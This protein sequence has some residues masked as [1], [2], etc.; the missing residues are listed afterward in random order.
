MGEFVF[1]KLEVYKRSLKLSIEVTKVASNF[2]YKY[3]RIR[4]QLIGAIISI[5][6]NIAEANGR[7]SSKD[8]INFYKYAR[9]SCFECI[10]IID[11]C[12]NLNLTDERKSLEYRQEIKE[13]I[14]MIYGL[15]KYQNSR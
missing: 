13:I 6:L 8:K 7:G 14:S 5:P 10:P 11:I 15:I 4:D 2:D 12:L 3:S 9:G 1:E